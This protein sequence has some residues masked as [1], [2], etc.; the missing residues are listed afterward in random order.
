MK[1]LAIVSLIMILFMGI[2]T[3]AKPNIGISFSFFYS[4]LN[5]Y[6]E[7]LQIDADIVAWRPHHIHRSWKP[8]SSGRWSWTR[9]GWYWDSDEPFGWA[10]YHY[11]RWYNDDYYGWIW[12]PDYEWG[13]A[14]VEW[15]YNDDYI[16]W[17]PLP[18]YASFHINFGIRFSI[19]WSASYNWWNFV[20]YHRFC[21]HHVNYYLLDHRRTSRIFGST[22]YRNN[23]YYDRDRVVNGGI[24]RSYVERRSGYRI[25]ERDLRT[26][27]D[28]RDFERNRE[29]DRDRVSIYRP[30]DKEI[31]RERITDSYEFKRS[32][33]STS[34]EREKITTSRLN[35]KEGGFEIKSERERERSIQRE[36]ERGDNLESLKNREMNKRGSD[37]YSNEREVMRE[38]EQMENKRQDRIETERRSESERKPSQPQIEF[39]KET[40]RGREIPERRVESQRNSERRS[41]PKFESNRSRVESNERRSESR[42]ENR[43][44]RSSGRESRGSVERRR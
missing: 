7:W 29:M 9:H 44:E 37:T 31:R 28:R 10:V 42:G 33:R 26:Y 24:D 40:E 32:E 16:G 6:G 35:P 23:Y 2:E 39:K 4:S 5:P 22:R 38:R 8:Y 27:D 34:L 43:S 36:P 13:P 41:E 19:G 14:W 30:S 3:S 21:D 1:K 25:A 15:R 11:G 20:S 17:A 18:P 12:I